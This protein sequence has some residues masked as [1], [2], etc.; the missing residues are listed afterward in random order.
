M[1]RSVATL[2]GFRAGTGYHF[3]LQAA[4]RLLVHDLD[5]IAFEHRLAIISQFSSLFSLTKRPLSG[6]R[7]VSLREWNNSKIIGQGLRSLFGGR[8]VC[9][10]GAGV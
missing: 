2:H 8:C 6:P 9:V 3:A 10:Y 7:A 5:R 4:V 1:D